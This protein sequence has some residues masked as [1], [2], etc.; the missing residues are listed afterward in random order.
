MKI[1]E[2][3]TLAKMMKE[4]DIT[5]MELAEEGTQIKLSRG[6]TASA[7]VQA[8]VA[9]SAPVA[10][11]ENTPAPAAS[12]P[13]PAGTLVASP[14]VGMYYEAPNPGAEAFIKVGSRVKTGDV[15]CIIEA[16]KNMNEITA[17]CDGTV[18]EIYA[19]NGQLVEVG[20][21]LV[22]IGESL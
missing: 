1:E 7:V 14:I 22:L 5:E 19:G 9:V 16:M 8:P 6:Q 17:E 21:R 20:Q 2:I 13:E 18:L 10:P 11:T 12:Q 4:Y 3:I 15:L